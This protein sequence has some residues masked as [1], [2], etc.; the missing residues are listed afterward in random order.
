MH[1]AKGITRDII[2][3]INANSGSHGIPA[4]RGSHA[5]AEALLAPLDDYPY[6]EERRL[7]YV[8]ITRAKEMTIIVS[9]PTH[10]SPFVFEISPRL[11]GAGVKVCPK[12]HKGIM[13]EHHRKK[14][15]KIYYSCSNY[16]SGCRHTEQ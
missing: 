2:I 15:G 8:A 13:F 9:D 14:D 1:K 11:K 4:T 3:I 16:S 12:C 5:V 10:I 6:A 7:W